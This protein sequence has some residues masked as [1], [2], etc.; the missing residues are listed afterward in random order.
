R[1][2][3][4]QEVPHAFRDVMIDRSIGHQ[5]RSVT[6]VVRPPPQNSVELISYLRPRC[7]VV[8]FG[9]KSASKIGSSNSLAA[10]CTT[11]SRMVGIPS[12]RSPPP[13]FGVVPRRTACGFTVFL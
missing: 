12:G 8:L 6:E 7:N 9:S 2:A 5:P 4:P 3:M 10:V 1:V 13:G 11:R